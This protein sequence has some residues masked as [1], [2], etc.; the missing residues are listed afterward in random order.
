M[1]NLGVVNRAPGAAVNLAG[2]NPLVRR[3]VNVETPVEMELLVILD[4]ILV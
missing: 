3:V 4:Y 1:P 2:A